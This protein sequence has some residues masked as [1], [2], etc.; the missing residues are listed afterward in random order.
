[1][2]NSLPKSL[3]LLFS[4]VLAKTEADSAATDANLR[5]KASCRSSAMQG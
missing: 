3:A 4:L 2:G 1:M 5:N